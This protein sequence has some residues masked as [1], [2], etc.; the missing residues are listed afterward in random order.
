MATLWQQAARISHAARD[1]GVLKPIETERL[2]VTEHGI[3]FVIRELSSLRDKSQALQ[4]LEQAGD[5]RQN[6]FLPP[7]PALVVSD[8]PP[9]H[10][11]VL[12][13]FCVIERHLLLVTRVFESQSQALNRS[14]F[15]A[16]AIC[17]AE[18]PALVFFNGGPDAGA[19][20]PHKHL[21]LLPLDQEAP[22][23]FTPLL[24]AAVNLGLS[25]VPE[26][27]FAHSLIGL[28][29]GLLQ[30]PDSAADWLTRQYRKLL[31]ALAIKVT[32]DGDVRQA[33]NLLLTDR[34]MLA[35]PRRCEKSGDVSVN[36]L[37]FV[38][39]VLVKRHEQ[40]ERLKAEG[41]ME[42]LI[43]VTGKS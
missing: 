7:E 43:A 1:S 15:R 41:L 11:C 25:R 14:D 18:G 23:P 24:E 35:V 13:K 20:Q 2:T 16:L 17:L 22:P 10:R 30:E 33:Y 5:R 38:G 42:T 31:D 6:P 12:N 32:K 26:L 8:I 40:A 37:G 36:A 21:Q 28:P 3:P 19:S 4:R 39:W 9:H 34:W 29:T 27:P